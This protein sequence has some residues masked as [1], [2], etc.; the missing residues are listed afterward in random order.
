MNNTD[1]EFRKVI[2]NLE[3]IKD[4]KVGMRTV[5]IDT[6]RITNG[7]DPI[8]QSHIVGD[9]VGFIN[10]AKYKLIGYQAFYKDGSN[11]F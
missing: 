10:Q 6:G 5:E 2:E 7:G 8:D 3:P 11:K 4:L 9:M 1:D